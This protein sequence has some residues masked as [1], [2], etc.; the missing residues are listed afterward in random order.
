[1]ERQPQPLSKNY[2][3]LTLWREDL[4]ELLSILRR[5]GAK[6]KIG[7]GDY[8]FEDLEELVGHFGSS[9]QTQFTLSG[10]H[11]HYVSL[12][13]SNLSARLYVSGDAPD[14]SGIY[15]EM[16]KV[17][18]ARQRRWPFLYWIS[19]L[20]ILGFVP[21]GLSFLS[22][23]NSWLSAD[24]VA[25]ASFAIVLWC[26]WAWFVRLRRYSVIRLERKGTT[27]TFFQRTK[28]QLALAII[29]ALVGALVG[30][31]ATKLGEI[32]LSKSPRDAPTSF[33]SP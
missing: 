19:F 30:I 28:D 7:T 13:L 15:F 5:R 6:G 8:V 22:K 16:D 18:V 23:Y 14:A 12:D 25:V 31:G 2:M 4:E 9:V 32:I 1:M 27:K 33:R 26:A 21:A 29:S 10:S 24:Y 11:P 20:L 17:L 3:P